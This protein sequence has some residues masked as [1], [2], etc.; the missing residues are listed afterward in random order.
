VWAFEL[1]QLESEIRARL[2][3]AVGELAPAR[4]RFAAGRIPETGS[5]LEPA[6]K[7][8]EPKVSAEHFAEGERVASVIADPHLREAVAKAVAV[9]LADAR[10]AR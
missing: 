1:T 4:I 9:S 5:D 8:S 10:N 3:A 2:A 6:A 7:K